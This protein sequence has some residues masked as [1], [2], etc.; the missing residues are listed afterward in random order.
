MD[1]SN[2]EAALSALH[3]ALEL[4]TRYGYIR[5]F[6]DEENSMP[7]LKNYVKI[8]QNNRHPHWDSVPLAYVEQLISDN[9]DPLSTNTG[10]DILSPRE[11]DVLQLLVSGASNNEI[12]SQLALTVGTVR[13]YLSN[14]YSKIGVNSR[15][16]AVL[17]VKDKV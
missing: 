15:T 13:I 5:T 2:E 6:L 11:Q 1:L 9:H 4:G 8:R 3:K 7:L 16:Q 17:W 12:A 14:I 10:M